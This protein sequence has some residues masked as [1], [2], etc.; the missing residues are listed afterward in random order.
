MGEATVGRKRWTLLRD[1]LDAGSAGDSDLQVFRNRRTGPRLFDEGKGLPISASLP[2]E[3]TMVRKAIALIQ[4]ARRCQKVSISLPRKID[5]WRFVSQS[6]QAKN[7]LTSWWWGRGYEGW[8][9]RGCETPI[10]ST[11]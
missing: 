11:L 9:L 7:P 1:T 10:S 4:V 5:Q 8:K 3:S 6:R 2:E